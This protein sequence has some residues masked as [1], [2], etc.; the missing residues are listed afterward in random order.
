MDVFLSAREAG[1]L[2]E[3]HVPAVLGVPL[4]VVIL[5]PLSKLKLCDELSLRPLPT[6]RA[7]PRL[8]LR[9]RLRSSTVHRCASLL[10]A[11]LCSSAEPDEQTRDD[12]HVIAAKARPSIHATLLL[13]HPPTSPRVDPS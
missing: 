4:F 3:T 2:N 6:M 12:A 8:N 5:V 13:F 11:S 10:V 1:V 9:P 7:S